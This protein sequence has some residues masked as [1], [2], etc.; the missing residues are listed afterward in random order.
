MATATRTETVEPPP[1]SA[2]GHAG[3]PVSDAAI[4]DRTF[5]AA[6]RSCIVQADAP[7]FKQC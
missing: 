6:A 7:Q 4:S 2:P 5:S 1:D 3:L